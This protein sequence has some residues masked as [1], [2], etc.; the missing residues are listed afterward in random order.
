V[1]KGWGR[2]KEADWKQTQDSHHRRK[3]LFLLA[4]F[5]LICRCPYHVVEEWQKIVDADVKAVT[6][7]TMDIRSRQLHN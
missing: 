1:D 6:H 5:Q 4:L 2:T 7:Y 3:H